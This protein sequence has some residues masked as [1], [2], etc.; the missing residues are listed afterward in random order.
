MSTLDNVERDEKGTPLSLLLPF[1]FPWV[2]ECPGLIPRALR[3]REPNPKFK[4]GFPGCDAMTD[5]NGGYCSPE[6]CKTHRAMRKV[7]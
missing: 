2:S 1:V 6:H 5:H 3:P 7:K 4:C